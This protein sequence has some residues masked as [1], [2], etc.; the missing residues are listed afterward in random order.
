MPKKTVVSNFNSIDN[1]KSLTYDI[2][3][4]SKVLKDFS[5]L[6]KSFLAKLPD[7]SNNYNLESV[8]LYYSHF[9]IPEVFLIN[10]TPE[11]KV[12]EIREN[13]EI[14]KVVGIGKLP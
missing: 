7:H 9:A 10:S 2:K 3:T 8:F 13:I 5:N 12:F 11:E 4:I 6:A 1:N 14:S